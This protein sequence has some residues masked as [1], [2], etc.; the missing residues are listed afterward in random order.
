[1]ACIKKNKLENGIVSY[2]IVS[3]KGYDLAQAI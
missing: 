2:R 1:M 3:N